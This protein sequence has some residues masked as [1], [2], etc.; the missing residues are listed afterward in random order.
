MSELITTEEFKSIKSFVKSIKLEKYDYDYN[1]VDYNIVKDAIL[2]SPVVNERLKL[3][4]PHE[5]VHKDENGKCYIETEQ[6]KIVFDEKYYPMVSLA[7]NYGFT[8]VERIGFLKE[9][10]SRIEQFFKNLKS[11]SNEEKRARKNLLEYIKNIDT[12]YLNM[13]K[14]IMGIEDKYDNQLIEL[15]FFLPDLTVY[16]IKFL[17]DEEVPH[18]TK[19]SITTALVYIL[20]PSDLIPELLLGPFGMI[21]D[22][23]VALYV[24]VETLF[25]SEISDDKIRKYWPGKTEDLLSL[26]EKY[27]EISNLLGANLV[28]LIKKTF[29]TRNSKSYSAV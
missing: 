8:D 5:Y 16:L 11:F 13:R 3:A 17:A 14:A 26:K 19:M 22:V 27:A 21:D 24:I 18:H 29:E 6:E 28:G 7:G 23:Y 4:P 2:S 15:L 25:I 9:I 10:L 1:D 12:E 20:V